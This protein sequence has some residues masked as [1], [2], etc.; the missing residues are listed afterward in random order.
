MS[1]L[2]DIHADEQADALT[3]Q[4]IATAAKMASDDERTGL[5]IEAI[6]TVAKAH[7][8]ETAFAFHLGLTLRLL[9][10]VI[11]SRKQ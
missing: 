6:Q 4:V 1:Q 9:K 7:G 10:K 11:D 8:S 5:V 3:E 2:R